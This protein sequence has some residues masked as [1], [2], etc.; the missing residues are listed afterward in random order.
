M[1]LPS[2]L[3]LNIAL[4]AHSDNQQHAAYR[5]NKLTESKGELAF[6]FQSKQIMLQTTNQK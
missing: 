4:S 1:L 6:H 3:N 5:W 2:P